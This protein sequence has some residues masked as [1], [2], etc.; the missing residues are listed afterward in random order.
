M[1]KHFGERLKSARKMEG[2]SLQN[3]ADRMGNTVS[4]QAIN[5]YEQG[6]MRPDSTVLLSLAAALRVTP[7]YFFR[8]TAPLQSIEFRKHSAFS[9]KE[10]HRIECKSMDMLERYL[11]LE[12]CLGISSSFSPPFRQ[13]S[14]SSSSS[15]DELADRLR[16]VWELGNDP[17]PD[18]VE[19]LED[20][21]VKVIMLD[22][23]KGFD[24][25]AAWSGAIP[26]V[27]FSNNG[28]VVRRRFTVLHELAHL[29]IDFNTG[30]HRADENLAHA[31][32]G[33][34]L[35]PKASFI[36]VFGARR[37]HCTERELLDMK[38]Y[39]G[40]SVQAIMARA[41]TLDIVSEATYK[42]FCIKWSKYRKEE[43]GEYPSKETPARF[44]QLLD[45][46]VAEEVIS[47]SK[48]AELSGK[49]I[50]ELS[51]TMSFL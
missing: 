8:A 30:N 4:R 27:V 29:L 11:D 42:R 48:A 33:A 24:G 3:L 19:M 22:T 12:S 40:I 20:H 2:L 16:E 51:M 46:A 50:E 17:I 43:P 45:R 18:V 21:N 7:D 6:K 26:L 41:R 38:E 9:M 37:S 10:K 47:I 5:K 32:A 35:F 36:R 39:F 49:S 23:L 15:V 44:R 31:F 13:V 34:L 28:D 25:M 1:Q 14:V